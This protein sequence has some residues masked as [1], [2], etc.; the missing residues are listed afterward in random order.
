[1]QNLQELMLK[2]PKDNSDL[3]LKADS[4]KARFEELMNKVQRVSSNISH[5]SGPVMQLETQKQNA[6]KVLDK[7]EELLDFKHKINLLKQAVGLKDLHQAASLCG[8]LSQVK[9]PFHIEELDTL[10]SYKATIAEQ[11]KKGFGE[12]IA[13]NDKQKVEEFASMFQPLGLVEEGIGRYI[14]YI[15][16]SLSHSSK[17]TINL[18]LEET[19]T[20]NYEDA[21]VR[22]FRNA[23]KTYENHSDTVK[24]EFGVEGM[25][26]LLQAIQKE[27]D[28][29]SSYVLNSFIHSKKLVPSTKNLLQ[30]VT[31]TESD[32]LSEEIAKL[33][34]HSES[35][36]GYLQSKG[37]AAV[38]QFSYKP[39]PGY[40]SEN[41]LLNVSS[42]KGKVQELCDIHISVETHFMVNSVK[43][44]L[45]KL[46]I[47][48]QA[49]E[50]Q[51]NKEEL[52]HGVCFDVLDEVFFLIQKSSQRA[53]AT[54]NI[55]SVCAILN[56]IGALLSDEIL[57]SI[58]RKHRSGV[59]MSANFQTSVCAFAININLLYTNKNYSKKL[60]TNLQS[61]FSK[62]FG[63]EGNDSMMFKHCL[64]SIQESSEK[65]WSL[66]QESL[67]SLS[68][69][70]QSQ[71]HTL[72][73]G[74]Y[75]MNYELS[76]ESY[77]EYQVNDP[78]VLKL[79][80]ELKQVLK[81]WRYQLITEI[82][83]SLL[84]IV[85]QTLV[86]LME[87]SLRT[88]PKRFNELGSLQFQKELRELV[89]QLQ[90][91]SNRS[92]RH[93]FTRL[94]Q[95]SQVLLVKSAEELKSLTEEDN[96]RLSQKDTLFFQNAKV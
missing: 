92:V 22:I 15:I 59:S 8:Q 12:A 80:K 96:W 61:Q 88:Y 16:T 28:T 89:S 70:V 13:E 64:G 74:F 37:K 84:D 3:Q 45:N 67:K 11:V 54:L 39:G 62:I 41:A 55:N 31:L 56:H 82:F 36:E 35:F 33:L 77:E 68:R 75:H 18:L 94:R 76:E 21:L 23:V 91:M 93:R 30:S 57:N 32:N 53:L 17:S 1:M 27:I 46:D 83:D 38:R 69:S 25:V 2:L 9:L 72:L 49:E 26:E 78:F 42:L 86:D 6:Q 50:Q 73:T 71:V 14:Q 7:V 19:Q 51:D 40:S 24:T 81:Q 48:S 85:C 5:V 29:H 95:I 52:T 44:V 10:A 90:A 43:K 58:S 4:V 79:I 47:N 60:V 34:R 63:E 87:Y 20:K 65:A 66:T